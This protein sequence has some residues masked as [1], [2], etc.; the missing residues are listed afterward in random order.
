MRFYPGITDSSFFGE[1]YIPTY[2]L[3][4]YYSD[5]VKIQAMEG[6]DQS[7]NIHCDFKSLQTHYNKI[8]DDRTMQEKIEDWS[9]SYDMAAK[10]LDNFQ[11][12]KK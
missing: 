1:D 10:T 6:L 7:A 12:R 11:K 4:D 3:N 2:R 5:M 8:L 9:R